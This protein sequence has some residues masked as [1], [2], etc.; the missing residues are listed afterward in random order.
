[1]AELLIEAG[2]DIN[3]IDEDGRTELHHS[4]E[5]GRK[6]MTMLLINKNA[7]INVLDKDGHTPLEIATGK[8]IFSRVDDFNIIC[9]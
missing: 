9:C 2:A 1:M 5:Y 3:N 7:R 8:G 6:K 4:V